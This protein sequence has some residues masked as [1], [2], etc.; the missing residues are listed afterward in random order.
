VQTWGARLS[1]WPEP[2]VL[3]GLHLKMPGPIETR[4][5]TEAASDPVASYKHD[6]IGVFP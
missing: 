3:R 6:G 1:T 2:F 5:I 4:K